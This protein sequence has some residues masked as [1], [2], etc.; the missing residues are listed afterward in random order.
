M[1]KEHDISKYAVID[2]ILQVKIK[3]NI[4]TLKDAVNINK[5]PFNVY[6]SGI[7][8]FGNVNANSRSDVNIVMTI[9]PKDEKILITWIPRDYYVSI[10]ESAYKEW[11]IRFV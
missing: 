4:K 2:S 8:T 11:E 6:I 5:K 7:D 10:N 9:N 3:N 1:L